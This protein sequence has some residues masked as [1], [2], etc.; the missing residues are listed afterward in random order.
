MIALALD[1]VEQLV[2]DVVT[3]AISARHCLAILRARGLT[4]D[5]IALCDA[6][7]WMQRRDGILAGALDPRV[8]HPDVTAPG[9]RAHALQHAEDGLTTALRV[10]ATRAVNAA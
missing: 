3:E 5:T 9:V 2:N 1:P 4:A 6:A 7:H 10:L 8:L